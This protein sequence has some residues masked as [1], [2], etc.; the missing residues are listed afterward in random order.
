MDNYRC[1]LTA[2]VLI[3]KSSGQDL[4]GEG[5]FTYQVHHPIPMMET[6]MIAPLV[7]LV[8]MLPSLS[9]PAWSM[10]L[11]LAE[12]VHLLQLQVP[13]LPPIH[14]LEID[15]FGFRMIDVPSWSSTSSAAHKWYNY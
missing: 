10:D 6:L 7:T 8:T 13:S 4:A 1:Y 12:W 5:S 9:I 11:T 2:R 3:F 14:S 15:S